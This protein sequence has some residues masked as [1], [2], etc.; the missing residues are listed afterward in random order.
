M[1]VPGGSMS[2]HVSVRLGLCH[3][4]L[5]PGGSLSLHD[6]ASTASLDLC[7]CMILPALPVWVYVTSC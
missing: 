4:M 1:L 6:S 7:H 5:V 2:L 3:F